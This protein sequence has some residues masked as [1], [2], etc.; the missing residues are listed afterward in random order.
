MTDVGS[1]K[2]E[3][4]NQ[5]ASLIPREVSFVPAHP[6]AGTEHSGPDKTMQGRPIRAA[7]I[8]VSP[9]VHC[10][11]LHTTQTAHGNG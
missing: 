1:V 5:V 7:A 3:V 9:Q 2:I 8:L 6:L 11:V 10:G 4:I